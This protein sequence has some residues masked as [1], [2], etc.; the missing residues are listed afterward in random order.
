MT[1][2]VADFV[3]IGCVR[4]AAP[5][6]APNCPKQRRMSIILSPGAQGPLSS[7]HAEAGRSYILSTGVIGQP[8]YMLFRI[9]SCIWPEGS[10]RI[11]RCARR[12][13]SWAPWASV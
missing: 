6:W 11:K 4:S 12:A 10:S 9:T 8:V 2:D 7:S 5:Y 1:K 13:S 3:C